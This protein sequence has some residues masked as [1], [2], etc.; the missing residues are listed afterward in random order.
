MSRRRLS[1]LVLG[2]A[3]T[4]CASARAD[5]GRVKSL[6]ITVLS[7]ML[8]DAGIGEWGFAALVEVDGRRMLFDT[9]A[10]PSTV[11]E[12][13][14]ELN[15]DLSNVTEVVISHYHDDHTGGLVTLRHALAKKN[16]KALSRAHVGRGAF[17]SRPHPEGDRNRL[18]A[19]KAAYEAT[20]AVFVEHT[21]PVALAPGV[22][23]TGPVPRV[24]NERN[25][26]QAKSF[27]KMPDGAVVEDT[28]PD[29]QSLVFDT[30][31]GLVLLSGCGHAGVVNTVEYARKTIRAAP[32]HAA[33]GGFHLISQ[34][35]KQMA[36]TLAKLR[37]FGLAY[38]FG[39]HCTGI[40]AVFRSRSLG[41]DRK[42]ALVASVGSTFTLGTGIDP[43][44]IAR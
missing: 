40:E 41:L 26:P 9:G 10:R 35:D 12:N 29:D 15:I 42:H 27:I 24:H 7:T 21:K 16:P 4:W 43:R 1:A 31:D 32:L 25:W 14:R 44:A 18:L 37:D 23:L 2:C 6:K 5:G 33:I 22:W 13:A 3:L 34:D 17:Y 11:L 30:A 28:I 36:W 20:G 39:A 38:L 19:A 8:A